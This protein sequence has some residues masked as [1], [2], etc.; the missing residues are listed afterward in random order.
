[1]KHKNDAKNTFDNVD[2][3]LEFY[4]QTH[5]DTKISLLYRPVLENFYEPSSKHNYYETAVA[6]VISGIVGYTAYR[7]LA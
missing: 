2:R 4:N 6:T 1:V 3:A 7:F 5:L